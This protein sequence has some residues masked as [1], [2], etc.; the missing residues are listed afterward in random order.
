MKFKL[1]YFW[2]GERRAGYCW[3]LLAHKDEGDWWC[4]QECGWKGNDLS[5]HPRKC[6]GDRIKDIRHSRTVELHSTDY[7]EPV[8]FDE[9][10]IDDWFH[11][12]QMDK[13]F[14]WMAIGDLNINVHVRS[15]GT[16]TLS[17]WWNTK[18]GQPPYKTGF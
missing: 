10:V 3:R 8:C 12:E 6:E 5:N 14:W 16:R 11:I 17:G 7:P 9:L 4:C 18:D 1:P 13:R 2:K 15:D